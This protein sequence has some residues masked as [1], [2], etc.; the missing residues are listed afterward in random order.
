MQIESDTIVR[1][2]FEVMTIEAVEHYV[3]LFRMMPLEVINPAVL[4]GYLPCGK[5]KSAFIQQIKPL[6]APD[7][8]LD[9]FVNDTCNL[10]ESLAVEYCFELS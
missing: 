10:Y 5:S 8:Y 9:I 6:V 2:I 3:S 7:T 4:L 1:V